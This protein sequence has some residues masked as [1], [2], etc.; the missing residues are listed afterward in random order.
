MI[1]GSSKK[2]RICLSTWGP[3]G[4]AGLV[5]EWE[6]RRPIEEEPIRRHL[7]IPADSS[8]ESTAD[9]ENSQP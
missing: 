6:S 7:K 9:T 5:E 4:T 1:A 2:A 3:R 8:P